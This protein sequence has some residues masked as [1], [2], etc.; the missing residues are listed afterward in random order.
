MAPHFRSSLFE[1]SVFRNEI[2]FGLTSSNFPPTFPWE[3]HDLL[4][5]SPSTKI[6]SPH[7][8]STSPLSA[9]YIMWMKTCIYNSAWLQDALFILTTYK[10][11]KCRSDFHEEWNFERIGHQIRNITITSICYVEWRQLWLPNSFMIKGKM[12][13]EYTLIFP[14]SIF[15]LPCC[16]LSFFISRASHLIRRPH[17]SSHFSRRNAALYHIAFNAAFHVLRH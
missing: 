15:L 13:E 5:I 9:I 11:N 6:P 3:S 14:C 2:M 1:Q 8:H 7:L 17:L 16:C 10:M 4:S 12:L